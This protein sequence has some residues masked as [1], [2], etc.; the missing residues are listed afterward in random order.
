MRDRELRILVQDYIDAVSG[1]GLTD[2]QIGPQKHLVQQRRFAT[3][4]VSTEAVTISGHEAFA[5]TF[6][7]ANVD[8]L[9]LEPDSRWERAR[10]VLVRTPFGFYKR[11]TSEPPLPVLMALAPVPLGDRG[12]RESP[13]LRSWARSCINLSPSRRPARVRARRLIA[14]KETP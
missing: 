4:T 1:V 3:R 6:E 14:D 12:A 13:L 10:V 8:Q 5:A 7:V 9:K 11:F 2:V